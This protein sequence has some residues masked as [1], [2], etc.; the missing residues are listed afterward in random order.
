MEHEVECCVERIRARA[1]ETGSMFIL[2]SRNGFD[3]R[4]LR[5]RFFLFFY[6]SAKTLDKL[7]SFLNKKFRIKDIGP[8]QCCLGMRVTQSERHIDLDQE[9]Y[10]KHTGTF[11]DVELQTYRYPEG[12]KLSEIEVTDD[13]NLVGKIPYQEAVG[14]LLYLAQATRPDIAF[15]VNYVSRFNHKHSNVHWAAVKRIFRY[16]QGTLTYTLLVNHQ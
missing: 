3:N 13:N 4:N 9:R 11:W 14:S 10:T 8:I 7:K 5:R 2:Q 15:A 1:K 12:Y 16:L 6:K